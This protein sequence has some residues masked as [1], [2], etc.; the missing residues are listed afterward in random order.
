[1]LNL[2]SIMYGSKNPKKLIEFYAKVLNTK[3]WLDG[4][5]GGLDAV[6]C[7]VVIGPHSEVKDHSKEPQRMMI[8]FETSDVAGEFERI[9]KLGATVISKPY[10]MSDDGNMQIATFADP[11][12]N[13]FQLMSPM[14]KTN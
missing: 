11:D 12:G 4:E 5:W 10:S 7:H 8:N 9:A 3:P 13:Y 6:N 2:N 1:M 14:P